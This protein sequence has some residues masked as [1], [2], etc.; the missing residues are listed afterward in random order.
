M[1]DYVK[2]YLNQDKRANEELEKNVKKLQDEGTY[3]KILEM[4]L[5]I[6]YELT[7]NCNL[8][9]KHCY[10]QSG[11]NHNND[12]MKGKE[13]I[14]LTKY[15]ISKGGIFQSIIS[16]GEPLLMGDDLIT[17]MDLLHNDGTGFVLITNGWLLN[18]KWIDK[19]K[20]YDFYWL[21]VSIDGFDKK[22]HDHF[23][24][25]EGSWERAVEGA[26]NVTK[27]GIPL[28]IAHTI[29]PDNLNDLENMVDLS[30]KLGASSIILGE[31][32][33]SGRAIENSEIF[34]NTEYKNI[35]YEK[36]EQVSKQFQGKISIQR[37]SS[38]KIQLQQYQ[39]LPNSGVII[40]PNGDV[41]IDCMA[42][43]TIGNVLENPID[44][45]WKEKSATCWQN[46]LVTKYIQ[47]VNEFNGESDFLKNY[48]DSDIRI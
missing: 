36:I 29:T 33:P 31:V 5:T 27:A 15:I 45:I 9:C 17:I 8:K 24:G 11:L 26:F 21:Q 47:S 34:M 19:F 35:M 46:E 41:R 32:S 25:V 37:A 14:D 22:Y 20:K 28:V 16:G 4:P 38:T 12:K 13:W 39:I 1:K 30:Y 44:V 7:T 48:S 23:R 6:Q 2:L 10:N 18:Q 40:R 42:P 43:F 3:P